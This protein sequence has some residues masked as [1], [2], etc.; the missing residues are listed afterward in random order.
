MA[1]RKKITSKDATDDQRPLKKPKKEVEPDGARTRSKS[2]K[3]DE[4]ASQSIVE[5][6]P[7]G[8]HPLINAVSAKKEHALFK[9]RVRKPHKR[10]K[11]PNP[12]EK[13]AL[14]PLGP[15]GSPVKSPVKSPVHKAKKS[16]PKVDPKV[17]PKVEPSGL[18]VAGERRRDSRADSE[19]RL[20]PSYPKGQT[21]GTQKFKVPPLKKIMTAMAADI[22]AGVAH[23]LS[24]NVRVNAPNSDPFAKPSTSGETEYSTKSPPA[25]PIYF[26]KPS[27]SRET[28]YSTNVP[29]SHPLTGDLDTSGEIIKNESSFDYLSREGTPPSPFEDIKPPTQEDL[30]YKL[31]E[32]KRKTVKKYGVA[33]IFYKVRFAAEWAGKTLHSIQNDIEKMFENLLTQ[34]KSEHHD[35]DKVRVFINNSNLKYDIPIVIPLRPLD[36]LDVESIMRVVI[37]VLNS[38]QNVALDDNLRVEIGILKMH[39]GGGGSQKIVR[40][41]LDDPFNEKFAKRSVINIPT[42]DKM[43]AARAIVVAYSSLM[44]HKN[45]TNIRNCK[46][47]LQGH[48]ALK[49]LKT[50]NLPYDRDIELAEF[51]KFEEYLDIRIIVYK[52]PLSDGMIYGG[53]TVDNERKI[54]LYYTQ[55]ENGGHFDVISKMA[56]FL[57]NKF[58]CHHCLL[59]YNNRASHKCFMVCVTCNSP[60]C[61]IEEPLTCKLCQME[62]RG[63]ACFIRHM[64]PRIHGGNK[65]TLDSICKSY[66]KCEK[67]SSIYKRSDKDTHQCWSGTKCRVCSKELERAGK[68]LCYMRATR[69]K[70]ISGKFIYFDFEARVEDVETCESG[71]KIGPNDES[72]AACAL[73]SDKCAP[74]KLCVNCKSEAC[75]EKRHI[76]NYVIA[77]SVC[78][79]C[80]DNTLTPT[81]RCIDCGSRCYVC[82]KFDKKK[83]MYVRDP[84]PTTCGMREIVFKGDNTAEDFSNWLVHPN[85]KHYITLA[86][87]AKAYDYHFILNYI[88]NKTHSKVSCIY[89]GGKILCLT[90]PEYKITLIDSISFLPMALSKIPKC[91]GLS[92]SKGTFPHKFNTSKNWD[93]IG[94]L[95]DISFYSPDTMAPAVREK[96][97]TWYAAQEGKIFNFQKEMYDYC[98]ED[99]N[100]LR[101]ACTAFRKMVLE[102]TA[103]SIE[104][105]SLGRTIYVGG[106]DPFSTVTMASLCLEIFRSKFLNEDWATISTEQVADNEQV[107]DNESRD[108]DKKRLFVRSDIGLIPNGG[109]TCK[110]TFSKKSL[111][112]LAYRERIENVKIQH[113]L[114]NGGEFKIPSTN[115]RADGWCEAENTVYSYYGCYFHGCPEHTIKVDG[116]ILGRSAK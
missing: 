60:E 79:T 48:R 21:P 98:R 114:Q 67:C 63:K 58:Y 95:P 49:L 116:L 109:Y 26:D 27:S 71:Y 41:D 70:R 72:C 75:G 105:D 34:I 51:F 1:K 24:D 61:R 44:K 42:G 18:R 68:H 102:L 17:E 100:I 111:I 37:N 101:L 77:H 9:P 43:C 112:W 38:N 89:A 13:K 92:A 107:G 39:R 88:L 16:D 74:C 104:K 54:F 91:F 40:H 59:P 85:H 11:S 35:R 12:L 15:P 81:S 50:V 23:H 52:S 22:E 33:E 56:A 47:T 20:S 31:V 90:I 4:G 10:V 115:F 80:V 64:T 69:P 110:D 103:S 25:E 83:K 65:T 93:Y 29:T 84:C 28:T 8:K 97:I 55:S 66:W 5:S 53:H 30:P 86:H 6:L 45:Y 76:A 99:V 19:A 108:K 113:A 14:H 106:V 87:N 57:S 78:D 32:F 46:K 82:S 94:P 73:S 62:C 7:P 96:F 36:E 2:R 3:P